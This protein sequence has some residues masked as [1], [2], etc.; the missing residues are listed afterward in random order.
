MPAFGETRRIRRGRA[1]GGCW[2]S[3]QTGVIRTQDR[4]KGRSPAKAHGEWPF[5]AET[6]FSEE[7]TC[8][9]KSIAAAAFNCN[10]PVSQWS[11]KGLQPDSTPS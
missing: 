8:C 4:N 5:T 9:L 1:N 3:G 7:H 6:P 2:R 10:I 11:P